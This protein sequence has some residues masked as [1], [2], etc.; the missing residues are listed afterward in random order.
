VTPILAFEEGYVERMWGGTRLRDVYGKSTPADRPIGEAWLVADHAEHQSVVADGPFAGRTLRERLVSDPELILGRLAKLTIHGRFPL[1]LK[2]IDAGDKLSIQ[3]HPDDEDARR[4]GEPDVG[5]TDMWYVIQGEPDSLLYCGL[6]P[7][8][9]AKEFERA[10]RGGRLADTLTPIK[11]EPGVCVFVPAGTIHAIGGG[12]LLAEIQQNSDLTY[13]IDDWGRVQPDGTPRPLHVDKAVLVM[14]FGSRHAGPA[15]PLAYSR[16]GARI[17]VLAACRYF[18]AER[19]NVSDTCAI[20]TRGDSFQL[21]LGLHGALQIST[22]HE[23]RS[24]NPGKALLVPGESTRFGVEGTG[25][26]L[27]Y[28]VP[29]LEKDIVVPLRRAAH[30]MDAIVALGGDAA[31]SDLTP[32]AGA[33]ARDR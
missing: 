8:L 12:C 14:H 28:Y 4:L 3:V 1:L 9:D 32:H 23:K 21:C 6:P 30:P 15:A 27:R 10:R 11:A 17:D 20:D 22:A 18:A 24:L 26:F 5:K 33:A 16:P 19:I 13:R 29:D 25:S 2:L 31:D 7:E